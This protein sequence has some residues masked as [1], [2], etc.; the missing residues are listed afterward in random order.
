MSNTRQSPAG[1]WRYSV[2]V[3]VAAVGFVGGAGSALGHRPDVSARSGT[4]PILRTRKM[5]LS[6]WR[7]PRRAASRSSPPTNLSPTKTFPRA[8]PGA[9]SRW[10]SLAQ[11]QGD[12][13]LR[14]DRRR[15]VSRSRD[16]RRAL[17]R[18]SPPTNLA[19]SK[20]LSPSKAGGCVATRLLVRWSR[21][22]GRYRA[23]SRAGVLSRYGFDGRGKSEPSTFRVLPRAACRPPGCAD[24]GR[25]GIQS[26]RGLHDRPRGRRVAEHLLTPFDRCS[27]ITF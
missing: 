25:C 22:V 20:N 13:P 6:P 18:S 26:R 17:S 12:C 11:R 16:P 4:V 19:A 10:I 3:M 24:I 14:R 21:S 15:A 5:G 23:I 2:T 27:T 7:N 9:A 1:M 8:K